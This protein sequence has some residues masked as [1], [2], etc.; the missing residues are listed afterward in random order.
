MPYNFPSIPINTCT[1]F[2]LV[3]INAND[4]NDPQINSNI[5]TL[6][7]LSQDSAIIGSLNK[8]IPSSINLIN[9]YPYTAA[10]SISPCNTNY[11]IQTIKN[12]II[13]KIFSNNQDYVEIGGLYFTKTLLSE[14]LYIT[15]PNS[16][17]ASNNLNGSLPNVTLSFGYQQN[18]NIEEFK[19]NCNN[20]KIHN[21]SSPNSTSTV[22]SPS[23]TGDCFNIEVVGFKDANIH[24]ENQ[25]VV[26][27]L[28]SILNAQMQF[29]NTFTLT[30]NDA[31][32][33]NNQSNL[34]DLMKQTI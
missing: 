6:T 26:S 19:Q 10:Q 14:Y 18:L 33:V 11:T 3:I 24:D 27:A 1:T 21:V 2:Q 4:P 5:V 32:D 31:L 25:A 15:L 30:A 7:P 28:N 29:N 13:D 22:P 34:I 16:V 17:E 12:I 8:L 9:N 23:F 20:F